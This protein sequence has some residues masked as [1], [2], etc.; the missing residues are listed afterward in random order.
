MAY[1]IHPRHAHRP[2]LVTVINGRAVNLAGKPATKVHPAT[3]NGAEW[4]EEI[5]AATQADLRAVFERGDKDVDRFPLVVKVEDS[6][7]KAATDKK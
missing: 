6:P 5:P 3:A 1:K 4:T 7:A 2:V